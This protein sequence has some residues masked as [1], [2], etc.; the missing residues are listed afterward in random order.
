MRN[1][2]Y[3][4]F[5]VLL[6]SVASCVHTIERQEDPETRFARGELGV[7]VLKVKRDIESRDLLEYRLWNPLR[8]TSPSVDYYALPRHRQILYLEPGTYVI[9][10]IKIPSGFWESGPLSRTLPG[11]GISG[12][13]V[14][15]GAFQVKP[16]LVQTLGTLTVGSANSETNEVSFVQQH[17]DMKKELELDGFHD[18]ASKAEK[19]KFYEAGTGIFAKGTNNIHFIDRKVVDDAQ[20]KARAK[21]VEKAKR[22]RKDD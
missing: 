12:R 19:G 7:V 17:S 11:S 3:T 21:A 20:L 1:I 14:S 22:K 6:L 9:G 16:G 8:G 13:R 5:F 4:L 2:I 10:D 15:Y 18:L